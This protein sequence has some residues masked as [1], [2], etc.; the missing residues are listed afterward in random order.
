MKNFKKAIILIFT[1]I[2]FTISALTLQAQQTILV[3][4]NNNRVDILE[5]EYLIN[6]QIITQTSSAV[7]NSKA[8]VSHYVDIQSIKIDN[9][10]TKS[11]KYFNPTASLSNIHYDDNVTGVAVYE[12][13]NNVYA[14]NDQAAFQTALGNM[15]QDSNLL[16]TLRVD[17]ASN[18]PSSYNYNLA[19]QTPINDQDYIII[20]E[21][22]GQSDIYFKALDINGNVIAT[23]NTIHLG[24]SYG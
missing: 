9:N 1:S 19:L 17:G 6:N 18:L 7:P 8:F 15:A 23:A 2:L 11:L 14:N 12:A 3:D 16:H 13:N 22:N 5:V 4:N 21:R 24:T 10:G 20:G